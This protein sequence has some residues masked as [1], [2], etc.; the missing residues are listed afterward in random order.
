MVLSDIEFIKAERWPR[1]PVLPLCMFR[2]GIPLSGFLCIIRE[3]VKVQPVVYLGYSETLKPGPLEPQLAKF[4]QLPY[5]TF[6][7]MLLDGWSVD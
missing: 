4:R 3:G 7:A 5:Q 6:E 1:W 2:D